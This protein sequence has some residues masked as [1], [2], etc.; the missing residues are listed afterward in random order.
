MDENHAAAPKETFPLFCPV[1]CSVVDA[2]EG[3]TVFD[4]TNCGQG[5]SMTIDSQRQAAHSSV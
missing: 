1:C 3:E 4:C 5:W 2:T